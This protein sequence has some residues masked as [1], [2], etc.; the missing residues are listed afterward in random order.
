MLLLDLLTDFHAEMPQALVQFDVLALL[1]RRA[2][3]IINQHQ[4]VHTVERQTDSYGLANDGL[5]G[6]DLVADAGRAFLA[7]DG[8]GVSSPAAAVEVD[9]CGV[10]GFTSAPDFMMPAS[11]AIFSRPWAFM[12]FT[13]SSCRLLGVM[14]LLVASSPNAFTGSEAVAAAVLVVFVSKHA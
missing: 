1:A 13:K 2:T 3:S 14:K 6:S 9:F 8:T 7:E 12:R 11:V 5:P 4:I 10:D